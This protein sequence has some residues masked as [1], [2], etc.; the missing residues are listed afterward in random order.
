MVQLVGDGGNAL[1][2]SQRLRVYRL[3]AGKGCSFPFELRPKSCGAHTFRPKEYLYLLRRTASVLAFEGRDDTF[4]DMNCSTAQLT[5]KQA[6]SR[7]ATISVFA[8]SSRSEKTGRTVG[9]RETAWLLR[10]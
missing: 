7:K 9:K 6:I 5:W 4:P 1:P 10:R 3:M 8:N 2:I